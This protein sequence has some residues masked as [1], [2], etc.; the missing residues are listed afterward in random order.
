MIYCKT[1]KTYYVD[2]PRKK[3]VTVGIGPLPE[4]FTR[5][6]VLKKHINMSSSRADACGP[7]T[8][9]TLCRFQHI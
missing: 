3:V 4:A 5:Y 7:A 9:N 8:T 2:A 6:S 1:S